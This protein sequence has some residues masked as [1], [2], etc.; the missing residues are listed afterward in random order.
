MVSLPTTTQENV[1]AELLHLKEQALEATKRKDGAFYRN[2]LADDAIAV[3]PF[4][5]F[6]K[7]QIVDLMAG[8]SPFR[9]LQV[10]DTQAIVLTPDSGYVTYR[11][12]FP[13]NGDKPASSVFVTTIYK[14]IN[15]EWKGVFYQQTP[16]PQRDKS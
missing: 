11:A 8:D 4:G 10:N 9:S 15:S 13:A 6:N 16:L 12:T 14:K 5:I 3:V 7:E 1:E 2:Y